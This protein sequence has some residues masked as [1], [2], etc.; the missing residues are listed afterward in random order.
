MPLKKTISWT[1]AFF[2]AATVV[3]FLSASPGAAADRGKKGND[4]R[5]VIPGAEEMVLEKLVPTKMLSNVDVLRVMMRTDRSVFVP[6]DMRAFAFQDITLPIGSGQTISPPLI[7]AYM[8]E[9][10]QPNPND[11][12]LEIGTGSGYQAAILSPLVKEVYTIEIIPSLGKRAGETLRKL[13]YAN[14]KVKIGDGY[15]GWSENAPFDKIIVTCSPE[16]IPQP[17]IDQ[18]AEGGMMLIPIGER[19]QQFFYRCIKENGELKKEK[20]IPAYFVPMTGEAEQQRQVQPDPTNPTIIGGDFETPLPD[21]APEGWYYSRNVSVEKAEDAPLGESVLRFDNRAIELAQRTK[22]AQQRVRAREQSV[23]VSYDDEEEGL[24]QEDETEVFENDEL[25]E[26]QHFEELTSHVLQGFPVDGRRVKKLCIS[27]SI[28]G[29]ELRPFGNYQTISVGRVV[30]FDENR[31]AIDSQIVLA[32]RAGSSD[33]R[34]Y[35]APNVAVPRAA[36]EGSLCLGILN[37]VGALRVDNVTLK[38]CD[39]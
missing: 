33:W 15:Q 2:M 10:L 27:C 19:Y 25:T 14:V 12:V 34:V 4:Q 21:G 23:Q 20:L 32:V 18:L 37:G 35:E 31:E 16:N 5:P 11:R 17:L 39:R 3:L 1:V 9:V 24:S 7:V 8:T 30:F 36:R 29:I 28:Q 13:G 38:K 6:K 26:R 22:D